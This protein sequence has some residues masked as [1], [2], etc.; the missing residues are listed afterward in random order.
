MHIT[1]RLESTVVREPNNL[2]TPSFYGPGQVIKS[3][4]LSLLS[5]LKMALNLWLLHHEQ[6]RPHLKTALRVAL[7]MNRVCMC[8]EQRPAL[9]TW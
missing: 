8:L 6:D 3:V 4:C 5:H 7:A 2:L 1:E 9:S